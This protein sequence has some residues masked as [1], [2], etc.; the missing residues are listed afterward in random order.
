MCILRA[1][2]QFLKVI[3]PVIELL[4]HRICVTSVLLDKDSFPK[5][6]PSVDFHQQHPS[7]PILGIVGFRILLFS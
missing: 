1:Y 3:S 4:A 2:A 6:W 7:L 5:D